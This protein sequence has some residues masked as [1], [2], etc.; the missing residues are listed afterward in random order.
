MSA[1]IVTLS[2]AV[3]QWLF[4]VMPVMAAG[5]DIV[6]DEL[7]RTADGI[8]V[9]KGSVI[10]EQRAFRTIENLRISGRQ[11][12]TASFT[13]KLA[14]AKKTLSE[15]RQLVFAQQH[16]HWLIIRDSKFSPAATT[17][18]DPAKNHPWTKKTITELVETWRTSWNRRD[19]QAFVSLYAEQAY[20]AEYA[21]REQ[22][23]SALDAQFAAAPERSLHA[24]EVRYDPQHHRITANGHVRIRSKDGRIEATSVDIDSE[25][26]LGTINEATVFLPGGERLHARKARRISAHELEASDVSFT[27]CP[28][29]DEAWTLKAEHARLNDAQGVL[30]ASDASFHWMGVT[31]AYLPWW[32]QAYKRQSGFLMPDIGSGRRRGTEIAIPYYF[33][34]ADNWDTTLTPRWMSARGIMG[35]GEFRH[36]DHHEREKIT[37]EGIHDTLTAINR[38]RIQG[39]IDWELPQDM[40]FN[41]KADHVSDHDYLADFGRDADISRSFLSSQATL[42]QTLQYGD[43]ALIAVHQQNL[44]K[45]SDAKVAQILPRLESRF[46][47]PATNWL[48]LHFDQQ[49]TLFKRKIGVEGWRIDLEPYIELPGEWFDGGIQTLFHAGVRSTQ[50]RLTQTANRRLAHNSPNLSMEIRSTFEHISADHQFR[51]AVIPVLRYDWANAPDQTGDPNFDS[52]FGKL[53]WSNLLT[54]NRFSG[55][56]RIEKAHRIT[57]MLENLLQQKDDISSRDLFRFGIGASYNFNRQRIDKKLQKSPIRPF[58]N[59]LANLT[60]TPLQSLSLNGEIQ[61]NPYERYIATDSISAR[62]DDE[63][64]MLGIAYRETDRRYARAARLFDINASSE[65]ASRWTV[66]G[67]WQYDTILKLTQQASVGVRYNHACWNIAVEGYRN[68]RR[69]GTTSSSDFGFHILLGFKGLGSVGS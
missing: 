7:T 42:S 14:R 38:S 48:N 34:P 53:N 45:A 39:D 61:F 54:G 60:W 69:S 67:R 52:A 5:M 21:E 16:G 19:R 59:L 25:S 10:I 56:D 47:Y 1:R 62:W 22:W 46:A 23:L 26:Q 66:H 55:H 12:A 32:Q 17:V 64:H 28:V 65:L 24:D 15:Q 49:T 8:V 4:S 51:H 6:A 29:D 31:A 37:L 68:N 2:I 63:H 20:P 41:I 27:A 33:A 57:F 43:W 35:T 50:Y 13:L 30:Q 44:R 9:A 11:Q 58:S 36:I 18:N 40:R 3:M